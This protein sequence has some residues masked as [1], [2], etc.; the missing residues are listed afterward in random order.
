MT[1]TL[2][3]YYFNPS[4]TRLLYK[5]SLHILCFFKYLLLLIMFNFKYIF[6]SGTYKLIKTKELCYLE[7]QDY[8]YDP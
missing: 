8:L 3:N 6:S 2:Q 1:S 5:Y 4:L 7:T